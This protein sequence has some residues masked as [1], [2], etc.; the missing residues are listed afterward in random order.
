MS[1]RLP[2]AACAALLFASGCGTINNFS[3]GNRAI[4]GP[5]AAQAF[6]GVRDDADFLTETERG[7]SPGAIL[8]LA[9]LPLSF[10]ADVFTLPW[11]LKAIRLR[12]TW[13]AYQPV[14]VPDP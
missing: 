1:K 8:A 10:V 2:L 3:P 13:P 4:G 7:K 14:I 11:A 5:P 9:D 12:K 6:G